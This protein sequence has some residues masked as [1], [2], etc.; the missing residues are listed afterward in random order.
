MASDLPELE[1]GAAQTESEI[2]RTLPEA[3]TRS[4]RLEEPGIEIGPVVAVVHPEGL[5]GEGALANAAAKSRNGLR[6]AL[7]LIGAEAV[8]EEVI[9]QQ[10][11]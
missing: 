9:G 6:P 4:E 7:G 8:K 10:V 2:A 5:A 3:E 1:L 11:L